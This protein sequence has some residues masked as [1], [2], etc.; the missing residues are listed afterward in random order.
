VKSEWQRLDLSDLV[1][2]QL[3]YFGT[4]GSRIL[5]SG[6]PVMVP[7]TAAQALG[8]AL[9]ELATNAAKYGSLSNESGRVEV[10]WAVRGDD[11]F[12]TWCESGGPKVAT[13]GATGFGTTVLKQMTASQLSGDVS[14]DYAPEGLIW[15]LRCP[16]SAFDDSP[17]QGR[18]C[19][20]TVG[21]SSPR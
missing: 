19:L 20:T 11:F 3:E 17:P 13:P 6:P 2:S 15:H 10:T 21:T 5:L 7:S 12:L 8:L 14:I 9:H 1:R 4:I 16:Q 18:D